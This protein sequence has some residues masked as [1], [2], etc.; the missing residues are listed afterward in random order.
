MLP[1][2]GTGQLNQN[3]SPPFLALA[4]SMDIAMSAGGT[5]L[6]VLLYFWALAAR[7]EDGTGGSN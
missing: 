2:A 7:E 3:P 1:T 4:A 5:I 6:M